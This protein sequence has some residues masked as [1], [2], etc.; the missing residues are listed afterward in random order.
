[1]V[2]QRSISNA[3]ENRDQSS[4]TTDISR[5]NPLI[6]FSPLLQQAVEYQDHV[7]NISAWCP[8][9]EGISAFQADKGFAG[10]AVVRRC[11]QARI[12]VLV[13]SQ[14]SLT[15]TRGILR[16][17]SEITVINDSYQ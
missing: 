3:T 15:Y 2:R 17:I 9:S 14:G 10:M 7:A 11:S 1:M 13:A 12:F 6:A 16:Y 5:A 8:I 4:N